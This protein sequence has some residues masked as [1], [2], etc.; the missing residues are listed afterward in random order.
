MGSG[1]NCIGSDI[2]AEDS[3]RLRINRWNKGAP[4]SMHANLSLLEGLLH[5]GRSR[6][7]TLQK[8]LADLPAQVEPRAGAGSRDGS[9][10]ASAVT[11]ADM[12]VLVRAMDQ[13]ADKLQIESKQI[14]ASAEYVSDNVQKVA[15]GRWR[16]RDKKT[17][18]IAA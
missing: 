2:I 12:I 1:Q 15:F 14:S 4:T 11:S 10:R 8:M 17:Q 16:L 6:F 3:M 5:T 18:V 13:I 7:A 9:V